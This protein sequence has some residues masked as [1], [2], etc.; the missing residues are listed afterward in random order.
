M[1]SVV[2]FWLCAALCSASFA[3]EKV[4]P[5]VKIGTL[6]DEVSPEVSELSQALMTEIQAVVGR[7]AVVTF[8]ESDF[9][10]TNH[11][12]AIAARHYQAL[13]ERV[14][15]IL[16]FGEASAIATSRF[17]RFPVPTIV[18]GATHSDLA[19]YDLSKGM[20]GIDNL[21]YLIFSRSFREDLE[22]FLS[23]YRFEKVAVAVEKGVNDNFDVAS[24]LDPVL[25][26]LGADYQLVPFENPKDIL[27]GLGDCDALYMAGGFLLGDAEVKALADSLR[28]RVIPS[29]TS[30]STHDVEL[31]LL[32]TN[33]PATTTEQI[34][35]RIALSVEAIVNGKNPAELPL[36]M[37]SKSEMTLNYN[38]ASYLN[39]PIR[40]SLFTNI[41]IVGNTTDFEVVRRYDL[42]DAIAEA[43]Q[44]NLPLQSVAKDVDLAEKDVS[45]SR[46]DYL[47]DLTAQVTSSYV[48]PKIAE[49][50]FGQNP[51]FM[52]SGVLTLSQTIYSPAVSANIDIQRNLQMAQ[53][54]NL[55]AEQ[56]NT[57]LEV[58]QAYFN[59]LLLKTNVR[60]TKNNLDLT[61]ENLKIAEQKYES[62][63]SGVLDVLRFQ[64]EKAQN[65]QSLV[66]AINSLQQSYFALN[67]ILNQPIDRDIDVEEA[68]LGEGVF[69]EYNYEDLLSLLDD[70][71]LRDPFIGYLVQQ[72]QRNSPELKSLD[73]NLRAT[74]ASFNLA[75][76]GRYVP[77]LGLQ[78]QYNYVFDRSGAGSELSPGI[79]IP[80]SYYTLG[81]TAS[82]PIFQQNK[83]NINQQIATIQREQLLINSQ[84]LNRSLERNVQ[85][86]V[87]DIINQ[88]SNIELSRIAESAAR[89]SLD[90]TQQAYEE[91]ASDWVQVIDAQ[92]NYIASQLAYANASY[93]FLQSAVSL[94]RVM[95]RFFLLNNRE[96]NEAFRQDFG[97]YLDNLEE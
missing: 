43:L 50:S 11:D 93:N 29:F 91:G 23:I 38:T 79:S 62:G 94:E 48:D 58:S 88:I 95:G 74:E 6:V 54:Q 20:S 49:V 45:T 41:S 35:R 76:N 28:K 96:A 80:D 97:L 67:L 83:Q 2:S 60:I 57:V 1:K 87:L 32:A 37:E 39:L 18:F 55:T 72:A 65:T 17:E 34:F 30:T 7:D 4:P 90:L 70:P 51:E 52:T 22:D 46:A 15:I 77:T 33:Q 24:K 85:G 5:N 92:N 56:L 63:E 3:Q 8:P 64:S 73:F 71:A 78:G 26:S 14:D 81:V 86:A 27:S 42:I 12:P 13:S 82:L 61:K 47:P 19:Q 25:T 44:R 21:T 53:F 16:T 40:S 84:D 9:L 36:F 89:E 59:I 31:G 10:V 66:E 75:K 68:A 69:E